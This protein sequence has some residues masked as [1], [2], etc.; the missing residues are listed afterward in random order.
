MKRWLIRIFLVL[1]SIMVTVNYLAW[2]I[3]AYPSTA[4]PV[5]A[6]AAIVLGAAAWGERPSPVFRERINH[7]ITLYE[8]GMVRK[9]IFTGAQADPS[10]PA[11]ALVAQQYALERDIPAAD[12]LIETHSHSTQENL[13]YAR[14]VAQ[15]HHLSRL[16]IVSDPLHLKRAVLIAQDLGMDAYPAPTPTTRY[17]SLGSQ[18]RFLARETYYYAAYLL[19]DRPFGNLWPAAVSP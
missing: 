16:L 3:Y 18:I 14:Q 11:E 5:Q 15:A 13:Y 10:E 2:T 17:R 8:R 6:D 1:L 9:L 12:I 19:Y 4:A 7:A